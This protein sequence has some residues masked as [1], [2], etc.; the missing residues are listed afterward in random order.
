MDDGC[1]F[2]AWSKIGSSAVRFDSNQSASFVSP[3]WVKQTLLSDPS[4]SGFYN[5]RFWGLGCASCDLRILLVHNYIVIIVICHVVSLWRTN[6]PHI[7]SMDIVWAYNLCSLVDWCSIDVFS[8]D[9]I[10]PFKESWFWSS[11]YTDGS[12]IW[13]L[14]VGE[15]L[16]SIERDHICATWWCTYGDGIKLIWFGESQLYRD[17]RNQ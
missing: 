9:F 13:M 12:S 15:I 2:A 16:P 6:K 11:L 1:I 4:R 5:L 8:V 17:L 7:L 3:G 10:K 14:L